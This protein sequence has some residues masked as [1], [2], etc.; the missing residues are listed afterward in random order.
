MD[1]IS[2]YIR[3]FINKNKDTKSVFD[4]KFGRSLNEHCFNLNI[5]KLKFYKIVKDI[6]KEIQ[7]DNIKYT[8]FVRYN[9]SNLQ[10]DCY[11]NG[12]QKCSFKKPKDILD[13]TINKRDFDLRLICSKLNNL[14]AH[15]FTCNTKYHSISNIESMI[16]ENK[17]YKIIF[18]HLIEES[19]ES[20]QIN[21]TYVHQNKS[22]INITL[23]NIE[24]IIKFLLN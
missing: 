10:L 17:N 2:K 21:I 20:Y 19:V 11:S 5:D 12:I 8:K 9:Y 22:N 7:F 23:N 16:F 13:L 18:N 24:N 14:P 15:L 3:E 1:N 4:I 6:K